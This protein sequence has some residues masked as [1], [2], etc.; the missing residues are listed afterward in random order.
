MPDAIVVAGVLLVA[1]PLLGLVPVAYPPLFTV[2]MASRE[3]HI[4]IIGAHRRA[5]RLL[6]AGFGLATIGTAAGLVALAVGLGT[7]PGLAATVAA[8]AVGYAMAGLL[9]CAVVAIRARTTLALDDLGV[10][11]APAGAA[12]V[13]LGAAT[14]GLFAAFALVTGPVL[15]V[16]GAV[17]ALTGAVAAPVAWLAAL[18]ATIATGSQIATGDTIPAV[19]YFPTLLI[20][21]ALLA[22]WT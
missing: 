8:L 14:G 15:I 6:N 1:A 2:W 19:L 4:A 12:E 11:A 16:L 13:L 22:G 3:R 7:D 5:W 10:T 17:L 9:W 20:G 21:A 18:I